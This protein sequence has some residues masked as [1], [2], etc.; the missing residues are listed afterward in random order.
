[1]ATTYTMRLTLEPKDEFGENYDQAGH[2]PDAAQVGSDLF[3]KLA[4]WT[5]GERTLPYRVTTLA[6]DPEPV[7]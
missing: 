3:D 7:A 6:I 2:V 4:D 1:M 5:K